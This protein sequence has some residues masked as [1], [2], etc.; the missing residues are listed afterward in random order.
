M[1]TIVYKGEI[2]ED[3]CKEINSKKEIVPP[4]SF[5]INMI[6]K[7][8]RQQILRTRGETRK[9]ETNESLHV[10]AI[11]GKWANVFRS[12]KRTRVVKAGAILADANSNITATS[13]VIIEFKDNIYIVDVKPVGHKLFTKVKHNGP[14]GKDVITIQAY[15]WLSELKNGIIIYEDIGNQDYEI[16]LV[17][18]N[19]PMINAIE[20]KLNKL[21][22]FQ[23]SGVIPNIPE[24]INEYEC[25]SCEYNKTC[26]KLGE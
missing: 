26:K 7:C 3:L 18:K 24:D 14:M 17:R 20:T 10:M 5:D 21:T 6:H 23:V 16:F 22:S 8:S 11:K 13:D 25:D 2:A 9:K 1:K 12:C 19:Q 4:S 15:I